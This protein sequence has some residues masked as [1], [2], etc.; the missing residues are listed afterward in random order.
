M[1]DT[2]KRERFFNAGNASKYAA[3]GG[4]KKG[5]TYA[6]KKLAIEAIQ[7]VLS[8]K[9]D[10]PE[11]DKK[12]FDSLGINPKNK[13]TVAAIA[14]A[15]VVYAAI[16]RGDAKALEIILKASGLHFDQTSDALGG[17]SNPLCVT[18]PV[19]LAGDQEIDE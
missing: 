11:D 3:L 12:I 18:T 9:C 7:M 4:K 14:S 1:G 2:S 17:K 13:Q 15:H 8:S 16:R 6:N 19:V 5:L 10:V